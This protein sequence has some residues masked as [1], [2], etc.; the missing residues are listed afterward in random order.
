VAL[1]F[2]FSSCKTYTHSPYTYTGRV[3]DRRG[4]RVSD[5]SV[6]GWAFGPTRQEFSSIDGEVASDGTFELPSEYKLD[7]IEA[8]SKG[9]KQQVRLKHPNLTGN[10]LVLPQCA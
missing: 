2:A 3:V 8:V 5:A 1:I 6:I 7:E 10:V 4:R 9:A